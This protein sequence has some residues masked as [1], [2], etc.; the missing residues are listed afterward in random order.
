MT[1]ILRK[2]SQSALNLAQ[3]ANRAQGCD[4]ERVLA[5]AAAPKEAG[6]DV[7]LNDDV[8]HAAT[9]LQQ[10]WGASFDRLG[11]L[12]TAN[13]TD[14]AASCQLNLDWVGKPGAAHAP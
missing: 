13:S 1:S 7:A 4:S 12:W 10:Q 2:E 14:D 8:L 5:T 9:K 6:V 3:E 11:P